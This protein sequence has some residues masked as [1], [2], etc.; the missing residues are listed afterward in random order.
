LF[1]D[2]SLW[3]RWG[4]NGQP[5]THVQ[6]P[7][8]VHVNLYSKKEKEK[9]KKKDVSSHTHNT[10]KKK[11]KKKKIVSSSQPFAVTLVNK[12]LRLW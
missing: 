7:L 3:N 6:H 1:A 2:I 9:K 11:K 8:Y 5:T 10:K 4:I 12:W